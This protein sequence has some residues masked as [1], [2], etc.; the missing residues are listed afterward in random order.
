[1]K[2]KEEQ[3]DSVGKLTSTEIMRLRHIK[4]EIDNLI[5]NPEINED[6]LRVCSNISEELCGIREIYV[7]RIITL[8]KRGYI[9]D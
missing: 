7:E 8:Y 9:L 3:K 5:D 4:Q 2:S 6:M 1:M